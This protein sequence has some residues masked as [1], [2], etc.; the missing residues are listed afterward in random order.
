M[1]IEYDGY[2]VDHITNVQKGLI[3]MANNIPEIASQGDISEALRLA[4]DHDQSKWSAEEY[5]AYDDYFYGGNRSHQVVE[6]FNR[7]WLHHIHHNP[8]HWQYWVLIEDDPENGE[9]L[10]PI[11]MPVPY[12]LEMIADWWSF[13]WKS[14]NLKEMFDWYREHRS[15]QIMGLKTRAYVD[16][17]LL[18]IHDCLDSKAM[19]EADPGSLHDDEGED[20]DAA[21]HSGT[22]GMHWGVRKWQ[23][24]DGRFNDAGKRRYFGTK[25]PGK[26]AEAKNKIAQKS[27][28]KAGSKVSEPFKAPVGG[29]SGGG[30]TEYEDWEKKLYQAMIASGQNFDLKNMTPEQLKVLMAKYGVLKS[31]MTDDDISKMADKIKSN[32]STYYTNDLMKKNQE[33]SSES[34]SS[35]NNNVISDQFGKSTSSSKEKKS[36]SKSGS[37][38]SSS[39]SSKAS[40]STSD[41]DISKTTASNTDNA[42]E[43]STNKPKSAAELED[44][45]YEKLDKDKLDDILGK[46]AKVLKSELESLTGYDLSDLEDE[47][48]EYFRKRIKN[49][50]AT[51]N[52]QDTFKEK[53]NDIL[54]KHPRAINNDAAFEEALKE[55]SGADPTVMSTEEIKKMRNQFV[56]IYLDSFKHGKLGGEAFMAV[57]GVDIQDDALTLEHSSSQIIGKVID[58]RETENGLEITVKHSDTEDDEDLYGVPE[59]KKF[60]MPDKKHVKSAIR[61]FNYVDPKYEKELAEAILEKAEEFGLDLENDISVGDENRF[62]K[63]LKGEK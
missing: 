5:D 12:I 19:I 30:T 48:V 7:A 35:N 44:K 59:L 43:E 14:G 38:G 20:E 60:P 9:K 54:E 45:V 42:E 25:Q 17:V 39:G 15:K 57:S 47:D 32:Y 50:Y 18:D 49:H 22:K 52:W 31:G 61:F 11:E 29:G 13:S 2:L 33:S 36:S 41:I 24:Y 34:G 23:Y 27:N 56:K 58:T 1:S 37:D 55:Y 63:Y 10:K 40:T 26:Y 51:E 3:W 4:A 21:E 8:H 62:K 46:D 28:S 16:R 53:V 6:D